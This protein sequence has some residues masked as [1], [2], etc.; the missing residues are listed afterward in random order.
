MNNEFSALSVTVATNV[1]SLHFHCD[2]I[3]YWQRLA[4]TMDMHTS[5]TAFANT[6]RPFEIFV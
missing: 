4:T 1:D 3:T 2:F 5:R 6:N